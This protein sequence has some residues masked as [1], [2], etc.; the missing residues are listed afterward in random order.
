MNERM[1]F[2]SALLGDEGIEMSELCRSFGIS[3]Q[4]GYKW[5]ARYREKGPAGLVD[6]SRAP[7]SHP[8]STPE[9]VVA[10]LL[11][12]RNAHRTW[13]P[14]KLIAVL[15]KQEPTVML[16]AAS[17][18]G[19]ILK[20]NGLVKPRRRRREW[21]HVKQPFA[22]CT[23]PNDTWC[24]DYKG[25]FKLGN[26][27]RCYP[28][29]VTDAFSRY[30]LACD[31]YTRIAREDAR[32]TCERLFREFGLPSAIRS[33][34]GSPFA[35]SKA[36][37]R[38]SRL[39]IWWVRLGIRLER[40]TP[41]HPDENGRHERMHR[42]LKQEALPQATH[43]AQQ[44]VFDHFRNE[45]N[46]ERPH[47]ALAQNPP[48][49]V[50]QPSPRPFPDRLPELLYPPGTELRRVDAAGKIAWNRKHLNVGSLLAGEVVGI[51]EF[52]DD[53]ALVQFGSVTLGV[54]AKGG[55]IL[56]PFAPT[57]VDAMSSVSPG[58]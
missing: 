25:D 11:A 7:H 40:I 14:R 3:R 10:L 16:P 58:Q 4:A 31:A 15:S 8:N 33:D 42:T 46:A 57:D 50:Y 51:R 49:T 55:T 41:G 26:G 2:V 54:V 37:G 45:F 18:V 32:T 35:S 44:S 12:A 30:L 38:L 22:D 56:Q 21:L 39:A 27:R 53:R 20:R 43:D 9:G 34:N 36:T 29:T 24:I 1:K 17:T 19:D 52:D 48:S 13:G 23:A 47:E 5:L 6:A 28:L